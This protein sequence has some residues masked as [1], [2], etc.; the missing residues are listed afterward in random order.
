M[1][2]AFAN[3]LKQYNATGSEKADGYSVD[4]FDGMSE[5]EKQQA[6]AM[7]SEQAD[8]DP[9]SAQWLFYLDPSKAK[10]ACE[11]LVRQ[12]KSNPYA[13][14]FILLFYLAK[15]T[16]DVQYQR[17]MIEGY[18][19]YAELHKHLAVEYIGRTQTT[20]GQIEFLKAVTLTEA[21]EKAVA[22][23]AFN[24]LRACAVPSSTDAEKIQFQA[25][26]DSLK[27]SFET[28]TR[29]LKSLEQ[30]HLI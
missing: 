5:Q 28:K 11:G 23:A 27:G 22:R 1:T 10:D 9:E 4:H 3:F 12:K 21:N 7:L 25:Y 17:Q 6:F 24:L 26:L 20:P 2:P 30:R 8:V 14:S 15:Y 16:A 18:A 13:A 19:T 29:A